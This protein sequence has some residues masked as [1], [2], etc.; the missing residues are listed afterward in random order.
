MMKCLFWWCKSRNPEEIPWK[1]A[2]ADFVV[3]STG[4]FTD[5][6]KAA[7]HLKVFIWSMLNYLFYGLMAYASCRIMLPFFF[8]KFC[9]VMNDFYSNTFIW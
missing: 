7:A 9:V 2:G 5:K 1:D 6:D 4:V 8:L 3:E